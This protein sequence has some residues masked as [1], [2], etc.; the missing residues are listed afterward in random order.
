MKPKNKPTLPGPVTHALSSEVKPSLTMRLTQWFQPT[1]IDPPQVYP[2]LTKLRPLPRAGEVLR[3]TFHRAEHWLSPGGLL[4]EWVRHNLRLALVVTIPLLI[5]APALTLMMTHATE[6]SAQLLDI[7][8]NLAQ[9]PRRISPGVLIT[10]AGCLLL[11]WLT[12]R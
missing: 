2:R 6:W 1:A 8:G 7:A 4:R 3:Y 11:R 10:A 9:I 12:R 5:F